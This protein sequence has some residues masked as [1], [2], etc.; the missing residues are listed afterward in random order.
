VNDMADQARMR[1]AVRGS[2]VALGV[3]AIVGLMLLWWQT[4][5]ETTSPVIDRAPQDPQET[6]AEAVAA[7]ELIFTDVTRAANIDFTHNNG[8]YGERLL[9][10]TMGGGVAFLDFDND[11]DQ[12]LLF[13]NSSPW[14]WREAD[15][16]STAKLYR[17]RGDGTFDDVSMAVGMDLNLYGMG[18]AVGDYDGDGYVDVFVTAVGSNRLMR[19]VNGEKFVD[20]T[21]ATG[22]GGDDTAWSSSAT[23]FD[24]DRDGDLDLFV[25]NYVTWSPEI[26]RTVNYQLS[27]I[28]PAYGPPTDYAGT[29]SYLYRNEL[30]A[31]VERFEDVSTGTGIE[32][33]NAVTGLPMGKA[34][35]V[36]AVDVTGD[37]WLDLIVANDTVRNF[38]FINQR[39]GHFLESGI[40][41]GLAFDSAGRATGAMGI[42]VAHFGNDE[43]LA[44]LIGNF[45]NEMSSF[46]VTSDD[47]GVFSDDAM[48]VGI[49]PASRRVLTFGL[50]FFDADLDG[51]LDVA[52]ANG[53]VEPHINKVQSS[54]RAAQPLQLF[55]NCGNDC[56]REYRLIEAPIGR[57]LVGRGLAYAD[58]DADGDLDLVVTAAAGS[59]Q[60]LRNDQKLGNRWLRLRLIEPGLNHDALGATVTVKGAGVEQQQWVRPARSYLSQVELPLTFGLGK[61][62]SAETVIVEWPDGQL[63]S[64]SD[65]EANRMHLLQRGKGNPQ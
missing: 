44:V 4:T 57:P 63:E 51:R 35:A 48:I 42:D 36:Q 52:A 23:F 18:V 55:W 34:L 37:G 53:H 54:Q 61:A 5:P 8:A 28:G 9:P 16:K 12:D 15:A 45:A 1:R 50:V 43:R 58:I 31:N 11:G 22:V 2:A 46:Y 19:N 32:V 65:L 20:V 7:P 6:R 59:P 33:A 49:G 40:Q 56:Q 13:I 21:A 17:N 60:L 10:E 26:D 62:T 41:A 29:Y 64:W 39:D 30:S 25:A 47:R 24:F 14:P 27:G 3:I 38:L